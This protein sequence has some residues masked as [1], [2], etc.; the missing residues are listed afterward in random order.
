MRST[1]FHRATITCLALALTLAASILPAGAQTGVSP[2]FPIPYLMAPQSQYQEGCFGPCE[3]AVLI[4]DGVQG[5]F[6]LS[7]SGFEAPFIVYDVQNIKWFVPGLNKT[8]TGSG[9][10]T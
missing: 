5:G 10:Y 6:T 1:I 4:V 7:F 2:T 9:R 3:C 8:F